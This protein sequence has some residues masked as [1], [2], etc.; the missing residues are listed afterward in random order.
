MKETRHLSDPRG[1]SARNEHWLFIGQKVDAITRVKLISL[2][3]TKGLT[4]NRLD[5]GKI[6]MHQAFGKHADIPS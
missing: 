2:K 3:N 6:T 4:M 1:G 5:Y